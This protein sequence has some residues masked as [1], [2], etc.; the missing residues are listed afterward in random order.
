M[1]AP[2]SEALKSN[3][4]KRREFIGLLAGAATSWPVVV[5]AQ[6]T[7]IPVVGW[8]DS[9]SRAQF[10]QRV[11]GFMAGLASQGFVPGQNIIVEE[12]WAEG[13]Y[14]R[15]PVMAAELVQRGVAVLAATGAVNATKAAIQA[16]DKIPVVFAN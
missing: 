3:S 12:R 8:I 7:G 13:R 5:R 6:Q 11:A 1:S 14:E 10:A 4:M 9:G 15:L 16:T 2:E